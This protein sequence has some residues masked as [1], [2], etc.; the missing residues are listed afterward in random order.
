MRLHS[1][2]NLWKDLP[3]QERRLELCEL[4]EAHHDAECTDIRDRLFGLLSLSSLPGTTPAIVAD[5]SISVRELYTQTLNY[6]YR[7]YSLN[8]GQSLSTSQLRKHAVLLQQIFKLDHMESIVEEEIN[9]IRPQTNSLSL[10]PN[11]SP[12]FKLPQ[13][14][15]LQTYA[16]YAA[17]AFQSLGSL[18]SVGNLL[19]PPSTIG[20]DGISPASSVTPNSSASSYTPNGAYAWPSSSMALANHFSPQDSSHYHQQQPQPQR[21]SVNI[22]QPHGSHGP[23]LSNFNNPV[24]QLPHV[25]RPFKCDQCPQSFNRRRDVERHKRIHLALKPFPCS[26]CD[27]SFS[28]KDALKASIDPIS[29]FVEHLF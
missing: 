29:S 9:K 20:G 24:R 25:D 16:S 21:P 7:T 3:S 28:R 6:L 23:M 15:E 22:D 14:P 17:L 13:P 5:Y 11:P 8:A 19:T 2:R 1:Q 18:A 10:D 27:K 12:V 4:L 26:H